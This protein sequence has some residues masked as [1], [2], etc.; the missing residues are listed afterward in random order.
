[1]DVNTCALEAEEIIAMLA[2]EKTVILA[3]AAHDRVTT[4]SMSHV[5]DGMVIYFQTGK[6]YLKSKQIEANPNVAISVEGYDFEGEATMLGHPL[7][8]ENSLFAG[9]FKEKHPAY[10]ER[11]SSF[12][13]EIVVR[14]DV[15]SVRKWRYVDGKPFIAVWTKDF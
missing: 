13:E 3:T 4:R 1:M 7:D 14:V 12:D 8:E 5:N 6:N 11:W 2:R 10:F 9:L 15:K